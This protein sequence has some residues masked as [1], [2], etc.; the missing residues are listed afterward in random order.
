M[1]LIKLH[2]IKQVNNSRLDEK[3]N[4]HEL[5]AAIRENGLIHPITVIKRDKHYEIV[6]GNR[7]YQACK[8]LGYDEIEAIEVKP[9]TTDDQLLIL[10]LVE[11]MSRKNLTL[12]EYGRYLEMLMDEHDMDTKELAIRIGK[13]YTHITSCLH[14][15]RRIPA[16][17]KNDV[18]FTKKKERG[19]IPAKNAKTIVKVQKSLNLT[20][21]VVEKLYDMVKK[22]T[23][24]I[25]DKELMMMGHALSEGLNLREAK[26]K[27]KDIKTLKFSITLSQED[28]NSLKGSA[29]EVNEMIRNTVYRMPAFKRSKKLV[30]D[31]KKISAITGNRRKVDQ[32][33]L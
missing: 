30:A 31:L 24:S 2:K 22:S 8:K 28:F 14:D 6:C 27:T 17:Y 33:E 23:E 32:E 21:K 3:E 1:K 18:V 15:Y 13:S 12:F 4:L 5:M 20:K 7:R 16:K 25:S 10:N 29:N 19:Q 26:N 9:D 11:N